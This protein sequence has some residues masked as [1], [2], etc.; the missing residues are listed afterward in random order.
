MYGGMT[1]PQFSPKATD[2]FNSWNMCVKLVWGVPRSTHRYFVDNFLCSGIPS[3]KASLLSGF[4]KFHNSV[5]YSN[6]LEV[7]LVASTAS[8]DVRSIIGSNLH[9]IRQLCQLDPL[10]TVPPAVVKE[11]LLEIRSEIPDQDA[12]RI[13]CLQKFLER[14]H[15]LQAALLDTTEVD[16][17]INSI[18][19]S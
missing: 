14:R 11:K 3:L 9:G 16:A 10:K 5:S 6:S 19:S 8:K 2:V 7:R 17:L 15:Q 13:P 12:W 18:C 1:W 4:W